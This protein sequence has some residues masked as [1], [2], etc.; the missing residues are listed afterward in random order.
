[1]GEKAL[2]PRPCP[3][4]LHLRRGSFIG[5]APEGD[6]S[7][8]RA[9]DGRPSETVAQ[10]E[11]ADGAGRRL[12]PVEE[13]PVDAVPTLGEGLLDLERAALARLARELDDAE[14]GPC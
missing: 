8:A 11:R 10:V 6:L 4:R 13:A 12:R 14:A 1:M 5:A 7:R 9:C 2:P 3:G